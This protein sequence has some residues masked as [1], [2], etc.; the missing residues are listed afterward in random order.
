M[1]AP[2]V[3]ALL[4][5]LDPPVTRKSDQKDVY[6]G[7]NVADPYRW[8]EDD[9]SDETAA[10]VKT[11]NTYT[12]TYFDQIPFRGA[13]RKRLEQL[14]NFAKQGVPIE[15]GGMLYFS[16]NDGL[17]N[18]SV[19]YAQKGEGGKPEV[20]IDPN[21]LSA[22]GT[23]ALS[24]LEFS[25]DGK[26]LAYGLSKGGSDWREV[27]VMDLATRKPLADKLEWV[28]FS[29]FAWAGDGF[30]YS[31]YPE[32]DKGKE[33]SDRMAFHTVY[34]HKVGDPQSEDKL[35]YQDKDH[36]L[37]YHNL[38]VTSDE[39][40]A[41]LT[42]YDASTG[43]KGNALLYMDLKSPDR[44]F[45]PIEAEV[46]DDLYNFVDHDGGKLIIQAT[47]KAPLGALYA[48]DV[49]TGKFLDKP[50]VAEQKYS[51]E[52]GWTTGGK[53]FVSYIKDVAA[54]I[55]QRKLNGALEHVVVLPGLGTVGIANTG[56]AS[57][58]S[59]YYM[60]TSMSVP[61]TTYRYDIATGQSHLF[62]QPKIPGYQPANFET[63]QVFFPSKDGTKIP[64]FV[65]YRKGLKLD[66]NNP[67][68]LY[69]YGGFSVNLSPYF[70]SYLLALLEQ[71]FVYASANLRGGAEY[72][73]AWH[74]AGTKLK[75]QNVFDDFV[76][77]AEW[78][79]ANHY[80]SS[81]RLAINGASNGGLLVGAVI[82]Q[83][84][85]LFKAAVPQVGVMDML[86]FHKFTAGAGWIGDYGSSANEAEFSALYR[87]S[88]MHN[89]QPGMKYPAVL[90]TTADHDDRVVPAHSFKYA[91]TLQEKASRES[92]A[93]IRIA[94][95]SGHGASSLGKSLEE[96]ADVYAFL[97]KE[98]GVEPKF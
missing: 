84:P 98:L 1:I 75:K 45:V 62:F 57:S 36:P 91:A 37:R 72:G 96:R 4:V 83:H 7:V 32:P 25:N 73:E 52:A 35:I 29:G 16:R 70:D 30:F 97:M 69:G 94:T 55:E 15:R 76:A 49:K 80:T 2:A 27:H 54:R 41:A 39:R 88:P 78:L 21:Q 14:M 46:T 93:L 33:L 59:L 95:Q 51:M 24:T 11:Q 17:Q 42:I 89:I 68:L 19:W 53:L 74:D 10:W 9:R 90:I 58:K 71:G 87:Y 63:K 44:K 92:P 85:G 8:L 66:G 28:K 20:L 60:F 13:V 79:I 40:Y 12:A 3:M 48:F 6:F 18:Q 47:R 23:T 64:M 43:K 67:A 50:V 61:P 34:F 56:F 65:M 81:K 22:D 31:R 86:R 5:A 77:A 82:N 26:Y 38:G